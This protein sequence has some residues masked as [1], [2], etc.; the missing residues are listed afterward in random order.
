MRFASA[1]T[2]IL[3]TMAASTYGEESIQIE[4][5]AISSGKVQIV[6]RLGLPLG[7]VCRIEGHYYDGTQLRM[8]AYDSVMLMQVMRVNDSKLEKP[9]LLRFNPLQKGMISSPEATKPFNGFAYET[10][11]FV[12]IPAKSWQHVPAMTTT[13]HFFETSLVLLKEI[14]E[15]AN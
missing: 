15:P 3:L 8:K 14:S 6:G 2:V 4:A 5:S 13:A 7:T 11:Q 10:G 9:V 1:L 12:G